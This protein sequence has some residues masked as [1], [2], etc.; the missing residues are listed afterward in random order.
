[1][2]NKK[3]LP[4][5]ELDLS[6]I[7]VNYNG[8]IFMDDC[9]TSIK[10]HVLLSHEVIIV[11]NASSDGS[12]EYIRDHFSDVNLIAS[13]ENLGFA[14]GNNLGSKSAKGKY[15]LLLNNDTVLC[16]DISPAISL[17][18]QQEDVGVLGAKML[19]RNLEYRYSAGHFPSALRLLRISSLFKTDGY[20][21]HGDFS[22]NDNKP[23]HVDWIEGSFLLTKKHV[24]DK[25]RGLDENYFMYVEDV[26]FC[27]RITQLGLNVV[28]FPGASYIHYGGYGEGRLGMLIKGF[29]RYHSNF[30]GFP[31]WLLAQLF[32][33]IGLVAR[34]VVNFSI[35]IVGRDVKNMNRARACWRALKDSPW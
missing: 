1:V 35:Y 21:K 17:F 33:T 32:L 13:E 31:Q 24:Y 28:Y 12:V 2:V 3:E 10:K 11:D 6:I 5:I 4:S 25:L 8:K 23:V 18:E 15:I 30:S 22:A 29:R 7:I 34:I 19:G 16:S 9:L 14:R 20:F 27:R 26:D